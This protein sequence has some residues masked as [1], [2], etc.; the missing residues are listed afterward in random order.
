[1]NARLERAAKEGDANAIT[2]EISAGANVD[3][4]DRFGQTALMLAA[5]HG[6]LAVVELLI[7]AG[8]ALD[9]TAKYGLSATMLAVINQND[10][11]A[12]ALA[13]AGANLRLVGSG[14]PGFAY[15]TAAQLAA[16]AGLRSLAEALLRMQEQS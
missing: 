16:D 11:V 2:A 4:L 5:R 6:H 9:I 15:K 3:A 7:R 13:A 12:R 14:A 8:A 10:E 1:V